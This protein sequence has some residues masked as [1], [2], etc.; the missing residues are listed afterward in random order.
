MHT[1]ISL[2]TNYLPTFQFCFF[3]HILASL[4]FNENLKREIMK[5]QKGEEYVRIYWPKFKLGE[6]V[7][8]GVMVPPTYGMDNIMTNFI[9]EMKT[10]MNLMYTLCN[11]RLC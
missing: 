9:L 1:I 4:H 5:S 8:R 7:V 2:F 11:C 3:R 6:E 10:N